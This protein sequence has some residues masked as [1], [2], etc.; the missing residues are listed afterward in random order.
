MLDVVNRL[1]ELLGDELFAKGVYKCL[2]HE[3]G[4]SYTGASRSEQLN[5]DRRII[6]WGDKLADL[7][8]KH[9]FCRLPTPHPIT[10]TDFKEVAFAQLGGVAGDD[11]GEAFVGAYVRF[12]EHLLFRIPEEGRTSDEFDL[13]SWSK[14][15]KIGSDSSEVHF[16]GDLEYIWSPPD[17]AFQFAVG[18]REDANDIRGYGMLWGHASEAAMEAAESGFRRLVPWIIRSLKELHWSRTLDHTSAFDRSLYALTPL[19]VLT[20][21]FG[22]MFFSESVS[23]Y[24]A[25]PEKRT[26]NMMQRMRNAVHLLVEADAQ[27][28]EAVALSLCF[29]AIE[30]VIC[31]KKNSK[32]IGITAELSKNVAALLQPNGV[33]RP[34]AIKTVTKLYDIR[35]KALHGDTISDA[36][37]A[38][39]DTACLTKELSKTRI[40]ATAV[41]GAIVK[42]KDYHQLYTGDKPKRKGFLD[43]LAAVDD[44]TPMVGAPEN[45]SRCLPGQNK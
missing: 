17:G 13:G 9:V 18:F 14:Y 22:E 1:N 19:S 7:F 3:R 39:D 36:T 34:E 43:E 41:F 12:V 38:T 44:K 4:E 30:A 32:K 8:N 10:P 5:I 33:E 6:F 25:A 35:C 29:A 24:F 23:S 16:T 26:D 37:D 27:Q 31:S 45:F 21:D 42:W 40:L 2:S 15:E 20:D 28:N 11:A